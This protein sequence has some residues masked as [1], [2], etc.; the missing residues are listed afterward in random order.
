MHALSSVAG[1]RKV[2]PVLH[3]EAQIVHITVSDSLHSIE[4]QPARLP[5]WK[6]AFEKLKSKNENLFRTIKSNNNY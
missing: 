2:K 5:W 1:L 3:A 6:L 4:C